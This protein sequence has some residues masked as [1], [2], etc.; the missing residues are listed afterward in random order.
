MLGLDPLVQGLK[1]WYFESAYIRATLLIGWP[2][3]RPN[4]VGGPPG[5]IDVRRRDQDGQQQPHAIDG[6]M[7]F[8]PVHVLGVVAAPLASPPEVVST[9]WLSTLA[10]VRGW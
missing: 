4:N 1:L 6:D 3:N 5:V 10:E 2:S 9:D 8:P 7:A